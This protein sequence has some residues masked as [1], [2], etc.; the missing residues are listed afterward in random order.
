MNSDTLRIPRTAVTA[1]ARG[2]SRAVKSCA[3][4]A[5]VAALA[6]PLAACESVQEETGLNRS[7]QTGVLGGAAFGG[8]VAAL[9]DAN[10]A[11]IAASVILGGVAGGVIGNNLGREDAERHARTNL[12]AL[13]ELHQGQT[14]SWSDDRTGNHG[15]TTVVRV[16]SHDDGEVCKS[17]RETVHAGSQNVTRDG[18]ACRYPGGTW[19]VV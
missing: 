10:P 8:I 14:E 9:A 16:V 5:L 1:P 6:V 19:R 18:T 15:S 13:D 3:V 2:G 12:S 4:L 11:W 7:T 17:Y